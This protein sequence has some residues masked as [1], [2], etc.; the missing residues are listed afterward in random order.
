MLFSHIVFLAFASACIVSCIDEEAVYEARLSQI[1][2]LIM[3]NADSAKCLLTDMKTEMNDVSDDVWAYYNLLCAKADNKTSVVFSSDTLIQNVADYYEKN[4]PASRLSEAYY[5]LGR[6]NSDLKNEDKALFNYHKALL[7][8]SASVSTYLRSRIY[9]QIG[10]IYL[11]NGMPEEAYKMQ[12]FAHYYCQQC[13]DTLGMRY[14]KEDMQTIVT[15]PD[16]F[17]ISE[18]AYQANILKVRNIEERARASI[19]S[20]NNDRLKQESSS[21]NRTIGPLLLIAVFLVF[22]LLVYVLFVR[23]RKG[24]KQNEQDGNQLQPQKRQFYDAE[25]NSLLAEHIKSDKVLKP[26]EWQMI[27]ARLLQSFPDFKDNLYSLY[28]LSGTEYHVCM[29]IK[30]QVS[31]TNMAHIMAMSNSSVSQCRLRMQQKV[32]GGNGT[33]KDWDNYVLSL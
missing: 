21:Q 18:S 11:R 30:L 25:I 33:A 31:P 14:S 26:S 8:D 16:T 23:L 32:F 20:I 29:L 17:R 2:S 1:D 7:V 5:L 22:A 3:V 12:E 15:Y 6:A 10:Y 4:R 13:D 28:T 19:L 27:E 24:K 9:A